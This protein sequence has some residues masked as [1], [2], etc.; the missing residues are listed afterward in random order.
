LRARLAIGILLLTFVVTVG[1]VGQVRTTTIAVDEIRRGMRGYGLTVFQGETPERF[2]VEVIDVL[3]NFRPSQDLI[4]VR[5][6]HPVLMNAP[7]VAGMSGSPVYIEGR[8]AG[9]YAYGWPFGRDPVIGVTP[10]A[11][12]MA[13][14]ARPTSSRVE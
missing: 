14:M 4:L 8:L 11:S 5:T 12:M 6:N 10:I 9:A 13:E 3:H 1:A 2:D 7:T